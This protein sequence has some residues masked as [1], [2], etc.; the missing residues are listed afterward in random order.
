MNIH[1]PYV[2]GGDIYRNRVT[3]DFSVNVNPLGMPDKVKAAVIE[4]AEHLDAYPDSYCGALRR[5]LAEVLH[6]DMDWILCGNGAAEL[7]YQLVMAFQPKKVLLP[8]PSFADYEAA[9]SAVGCS[10]SYYPLRREEGFIITERILSF[11]SEQT[12]MLMLCN[13]NNPTG[14]LI[15]RDLLERILE[16]C[17]ETGTLL[18]VDECFGELTD[19]ETPSLLNVLRPGDRVFLL[20]AFTKIYSMAGL[21]LGYAICPE[22]EMVDR[23]CLQSQPWNVSSLAQAA[24]VAALD[25]EG[26]GE[27]T[28]ALIREEKR[29]LVQELEKMGISVLHSDVNFLLLSGVPGLYEKLLRKGILIRNCDNYHG[30]GEGDCR[31]AVRT[32]EENEALIK[33]I[34]EVFHG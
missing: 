22:Q 25:C 3:L 33:A 10:P 29:Y 28:R 23:I 34:Q 16:R 6:T 31:I 2:H 21:R 5:R 27:R 32:H 4:A 24:G 14:K 8:V 15:E 12:D 20:R 1:A 19:E 30:L 13:P 26:W 17:R 9:L 18:F 11:I 7:I